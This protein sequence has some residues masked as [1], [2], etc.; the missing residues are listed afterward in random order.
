MLDPLSVVTGTGF[1]ALAA[2]AALPS[3]AEPLVGV[4]GVVVVGGAA[5]GWQPNS[6]SVN[7]QKIAAQAALNETG[8]SKLVFEGGNAG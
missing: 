3:E 5:T 7:V 4:A 1:S 8:M 2:G 6:V